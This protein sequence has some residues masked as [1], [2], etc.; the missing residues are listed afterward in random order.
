MGLFDRIYILTLGL[1]LAGFLC[2]HIEF[3][4]PA[5]SLT[6]L[7]QGGPISLTRM[8]R[9]RIL[10]FHCCDEKKSKGVIDLVDSPL[11]FS[12]SDSK[13]RNWMRLNATGKYKLPNQLK[14]LENI[15]LSQEREQANDDL[16]LEI[17]L[18]FWHIGGH[19]DGY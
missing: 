12:Y 17:P 19:L 9:S 7:H 2:A 16:I 14:L 15:T 8:C 6:G 10:H 4:S 13:Y 5:H 1:K 3:P 18:A 11:N